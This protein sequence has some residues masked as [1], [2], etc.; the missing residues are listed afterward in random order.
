MNGTAEAME[1]MDK[2]YEKVTTEVM[3][4]TEVFDTAA[5]KNTEG[6]NRAAGAKGTVESTGTAAE[7]GEA[8]EMDTAR[9]N[10]WQRARMRQGGGTRRW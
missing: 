8:E 2:A 7:K 4:I 10:T 1:A 9:I 5:I 6:I 3:N